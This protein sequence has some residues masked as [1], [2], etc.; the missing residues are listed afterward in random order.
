MAHPMKLSHVVM[1]TNQISEMRDWYC[2]VL[3]AKPAFENE[4]M[5]FLAYDEE[6]HRIGLLS[7]DDYAVPERAT[8]GLQHISFTYESLWT[9]LENYERL[10]SEG[11]LPVWS[12]N[13]GPTV[14]IYYS[15]PD[16]N[17]LELQVDVFGTSDEAN[18]FM[19][20]EIYQKD[21]VGV[22]FDPDEMFAQLRAGASF[23]ALARRT[24]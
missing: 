21:P 13:H 2:T 24:R 16:R 18:A 1:Q 12:V 4:R 3:C 8:V 11:I 22:D 7:L 19:V 23:E 5:A 17:R 9:L 15:D 6:H 14:S 10:K 20:G